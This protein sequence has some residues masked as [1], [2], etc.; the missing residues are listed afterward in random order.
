MAAREARVRD[1]YGA[2]TPPD[3]VIDDIFL[4]SGASLATLAKAALL[5]VID[6]RDRWMWSDELRPRMNT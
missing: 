3:A 1:C 2:V 5:A 4:C 6:R